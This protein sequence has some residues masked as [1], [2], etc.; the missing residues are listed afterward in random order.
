MRQTVKALERAGT[1][2]NR[3]AGIREHMYTKFRNGRN[4][5]NTIHYWHLKT[6]AKEAAMLMDFARFKASNYFL[7]QFKRRYKIISHKITRFITRRDLT[8]DTVMRTRASE[9][10]REVTDYVSANAIQADMVFNTD[11]SRFEYEIT[12]N[13]TLS[14]TGEKTTE[15]TVASVASS[16]HSYTI[17]VLIS[18]SGRLAM[19]FYIC[20]QEGGGKFGK[21]VSETL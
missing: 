13:R 8:L 9:F 3:H 18:M 2:E 14:M 21:C 4:V 20:F 6:W 17:Q 5:G 11:Q 7:H 12:S 1:I 16:T 15:A 10:V 19:K